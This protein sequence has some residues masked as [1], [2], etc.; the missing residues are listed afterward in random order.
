MVHFDTL[1]FDPEAA[2]QVD[3]EK[4]LKIRAEEQAHRF[5]GIIFYTM[6]G[7][8]A[9]VALVWLIGL[10]CAWPDPDAGIP[11]YALVGVKVALLT[12]VLLTV[13]ISLMRFVIRCARQDNKDKED[14]PNPG[15]SWEEVV[16]A[17]LKNLKL[18]TGS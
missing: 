16:K 5:R 3:H 12:A 7:F 17:L 2:A 15:N 11:A 4:L 14:L 10:T 9:I 8:F 13:A 18:P 1:P 6:L